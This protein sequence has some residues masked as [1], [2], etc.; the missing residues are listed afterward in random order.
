MSKMI[1]VPGLEITPARL[2]SSSLPALDYA[3]WDPAKAYL[4]GDRV[5]IGQINYEALA[6]NTNRNPVTD[7]VTPAVWLN[8]GW[9]NRYR[10]FNK[11]I[12]NTWKAGTFSSAAD[13]IDLTI[14]P[15]Q[16]V[17]S[18]GLVGVDASSVRIIMTQPGN[19][20]PIR[21]ETF[22]MS[23]PSGRGWYQ[24][25]FSRFKSRKN[26]A[27]LD[28]PPASN[29]DIRVIVSAPGGTAKVGMMILGWSEAIGTAV[30]GTSFGRKGYTTMKEEFDGSITMTKHGARQ[31]VNYQIVMEGEEIDNAALT[32]DQVRDTASLYVGSVDL[33]YTIIAGTYDDTDVGL[34]TFGLGTSTIVVR[35]LM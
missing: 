5:T 26:L 21:D 8:L 1:V 32:L 33:A 11:Q 20:V 31:L 9:V 6:G 2:V 15:G 29:A 19:P 23:R 18:L 22:V 3:T 7:T 14:R 10:M 13:V 35:S 16:R 30:Y 12:G 34:P 28:L 17:N 25:F 4:I 24:H 27:V